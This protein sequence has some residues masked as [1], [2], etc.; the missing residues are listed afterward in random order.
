MAFPFGIAFRSVTSFQALAW[1]LEVFAFACTLEEA[2]LAKTLEVFV[3][4]IGLVTLPFGGQAC[5]PLYDPLLVINDAV[6]NIPIRAT[7]PNTARNKN[8]S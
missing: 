1:T 2:A 5:H 6:D 7:F 8:D 4:A 3:F